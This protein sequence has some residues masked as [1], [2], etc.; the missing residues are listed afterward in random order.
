[1]RL[2]GLGQLK[3][4]VTSLGIEP[5]TFRLVALPRAPNSSVQ[6]PCLC[7][8]SRSADQEKRSYVVDKNPAVIMIEGCNADMV[9]LELNLFASGYL[10]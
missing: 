10:N 7:S 4:P 9:S 1:M 3:K 6:S 2:E 5:A 8:D